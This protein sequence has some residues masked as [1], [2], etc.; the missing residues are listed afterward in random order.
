MTDSK[1]QWSKTTNP[2]APC[3]CY[4][5]NGLLC[6]EGS[7]SRTGVPVLQSDHCGRV[8]ETLFRS[9]TT[10]TVVH[11]PDSLLLDPKDQSPCSTPRTRSRHTNRTRTAVETPPRS[12]VGLPSGSGREV[13]RNP[14]RRTSLR[15]LESTTVGT[16]QSRSLL[17]PIK[18]TCRG[19]G[20]T[21]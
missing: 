5:V 21:L 17:G 20:G 3:L 16:K 1:R 2:L 19:E 12:P 11:R 9:P 18:R 15:N 4:S 6:V 8:H 10:R 14:Q 13:S 7:R